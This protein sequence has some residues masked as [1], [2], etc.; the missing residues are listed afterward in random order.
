M[1]QDR[2]AVA[3]LGPVSVRGAAAPFRRTAALELVVYLA[4]HREGARLGECALAL[5]PDRA[6][7]AATV[8]STASDARRGLGRA[9][10]GS[11]LLPRGGLLR[12]HPSVTTDVE[13]FARLSGAPDLRGQEHALS[14]IRGPLFAGL[15]R[16]DWAVLDGTASAVEHVVVQAALHCAGALLRCGEGARAEA[17]VRRALRLSPYD[18][19]LYRA[20]LTATAA[21]GNCALLRSTMAQLRILAGE[22]PDV[23]RRPRTSPGGALHPDT[24]DLYRDLLRCSPATGRFPARL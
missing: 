4:L 3:V 15:R 11:P 8:H 22:S 19:R 5:W 10:D 7:S 23:A 17:V 16:T 21:Q 24:T 9:A 14:L 18:E 13:D 12:L 2:V 1:E 20:L 6:V